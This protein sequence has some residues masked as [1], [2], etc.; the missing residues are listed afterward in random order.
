MVIIE[1]VSAG[2]IEWAHLLA[3][4]IWVEA[5]RELR[6]AGGSSA[7][8][9]AALP[10]WQG[11]MADEDAYVARDRPDARA[12][13]V[14]D[15]SVGALS[16]GSRRQRPT[17]SDDGVGVQPPGRPGQPIDR[18]GHRDRRDHAPVGAEHRRRDRR[19]A[20]L[21]LG[22][23]RRPASAAHRRQRRGG[24][25]CPAQRRRP[26]RPRGSQA[27]STCAADP[28]VIGSSAPTGTVSRSPLDRSAAATQRRTLPARR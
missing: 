25:P 20:G 11:W 4:L 9:T 19:D 8:A 3:F 5:P 17:G 28:A 26:P 15:G 27:S 21:A 1:G 2:R 14:V 16:A 22:D 23:A 6:C 7:T 24:E 10:L 18:A 12:D 13:V